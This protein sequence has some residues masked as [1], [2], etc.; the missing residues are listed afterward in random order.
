MIAELP[1]PPPGKSGWPWTMESPESPLGDQVWGIDTAYPKI[2]MVTPSFNQGSYIEETIRSVLLQ[3]Y[4]RLEYF[5]VDGGSTD[6]TVAILEKYS[7]WISK[8]VS[9][10]DKGQSDAINKGFSWATGVLGNWLNSDDVL[11]PGALDVVAQAW[12]QNGDATLF[13]APRYCIDAVGDV[14]AVQNTWSVKWREYLVGL[15]DFPQDSTFFSLEEFRR[16]G[17]LEQSLK[18]SMDVLLFHELLSRAQKVCCID[19]PF[20]KLRVYPEMKTKRADPNRKIEAELLRMRTKRGWI[21]DTLIR[22]SYPIR[23]TSA[24]CHLWNTLVSKRVAVRFRYDVLK[25]AWDSEP[26]R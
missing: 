17:G 26:L 24:F 13:T 25:C 19:K 3:G 15:S 14:F 23:A 10:P 9:E 1:P 7:P 8:L 21:F 11:L 4:P 6:E 22:A 18:Y 2:T 20:S 16:V 5:V 12:T